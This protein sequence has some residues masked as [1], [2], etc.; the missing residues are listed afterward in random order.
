KELRK[1]TYFASIV[2]D[3]KPTWTIQ[4]ELETSSAKASAT[5]GRQ[6]TRYSAHAL[7]EYKGRFNPQLVAFLLNYLGVSRTSKV[8]DPFCGSGAVFRRC[9]RHNCSLHFGARLNGS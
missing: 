7:H 8:F 3:G 4:H 2:A 5:T 1:L 9:L 6:A